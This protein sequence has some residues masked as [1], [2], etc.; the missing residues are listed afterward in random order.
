MRTLLLTSAG[1]E[2]RDEILKIL[3]KSPDQT[4]VAYITTAANPAPNPWWVD[5]DKKRMEEV[6]LQ[7]IS[8]DIKDKKESELQE[9]LKGFDVIFVQGGN[10]FKV[11]QR[12]RVRYS[13]ERTARARCNLYW[14][15][16]W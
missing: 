11:R 10:T 1:M 13:G 12:E 16:C 14:G 8:I 2:V 15:K 5:E 4:K 9:L 3:P 6:G 7:V